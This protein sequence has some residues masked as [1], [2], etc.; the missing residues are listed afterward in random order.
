M[1]HANSSAHKLALLAMSDTPVLWALCMQIWIFWGILSYISSKLM[2]LP[3]PAGVCSIYLPRRALA[4]SLPPNRTHYRVVSC[5]IPPT[6]VPLPG[7]SLGHKLAACS[8]LSLQL[9]PF[10]PYCL[11]LFT[12]C[13]SHVLSFFLYLVHYRG[14]PVA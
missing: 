6:L 9:S 2:L 5:H 1:A 12:L 4:R 7:P 13:L 11:V 3:S 10:T 8:S 14:D